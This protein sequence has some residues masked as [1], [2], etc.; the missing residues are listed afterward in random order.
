MTLYEIYIDPNFFVK[1]D[2]SRN[3][4]VFYKGKKISCRISAMKI[5]VLENK[6]DQAVCEL[7]E[8]AHKQEMVLIKG[9]R[10]E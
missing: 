7:I 9:K 1:E 5:V 6:D 8:D 3:I 10:R 2:V 4:E